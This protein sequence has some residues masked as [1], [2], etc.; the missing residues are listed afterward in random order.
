MKPRKNETLLRS[1]FYFNRDERKGILTLI[2]I[3]IAVIVLPGWIA[4]FF[5]PD[6]PQV[7]FTVIPARMAQHTNGLPHQAK[8]VVFTDSIKKKIPIAI[9]ELN[10]ADSASIV[11]L[12][13]I[14]PALSHRIIE[15]RQQLGGFVLLDQ[16]KE[17][18]G[19]DE[20]I[21]FDLKDR[22]R[23]DASKAVKFNVNTVDFESLSTHPYFK[24]K[25][26]RAIVN[27]RT[28]HG[29]YT[30]LNELRNIV[31]VNDSVW[32]RITRYLTL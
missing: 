27:Y 18:W 16:L 31:L 4:R 22:I 24:Y 9:I 20:D 8:R 1:L 2:L 10:T 26:S 23:V 32:V 6:I 14:G 3:L 29:I 7:S 12:Y 25:L 13:R 19:F 5:P 11:S 28:Q 30:S 15:Y 17:I 21:L